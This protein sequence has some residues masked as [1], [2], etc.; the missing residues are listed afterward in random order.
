[1][2][3]RYL[4]PE[5]I[6]QITALL[7]ECPELAEDDVLRADMIEGETDAFKF[8]QD[9]EHKRQDACAMMDGIATRIDTLAQRSRRIDRREQAIRKMMHKI[10]DAADLRKVELPEATISIRNGTPKVIIIEQNELPDYYIRI[11]REPD[12]TLIGAALKAGSTVPGA[13]L[14]NSEPTI[15]I[16]IG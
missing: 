7:L 14:S 13:A 15:S 10:L 9:L 8:L 5:T 11:K 16:R 12:K 6:R 1:V 3:N 2:S 4:N